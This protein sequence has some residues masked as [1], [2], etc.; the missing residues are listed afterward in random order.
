MEPNDG[1]LHIH[2]G[3]HTF[4]TP[5]TYSGRVRVSNCIY[6]DGCAAF[7]QMSLELGYVL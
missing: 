3:F 7:T 6:L 1:Q 4:H 2:I 5:L